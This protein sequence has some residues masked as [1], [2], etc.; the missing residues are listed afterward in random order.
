MTLLESLKAEI[1]GIE[2]LTDNEI[3]RNIK[4]AVSILSDKTNITYS[5]T[6][7][8]DI[9]TIDDIIEVAIALY[10]DYAVCMKSATVSSSTGVEQLKYND[11]FN[12]VDKKYSS[13]STGGGV[14]A[15]KLIEQAF[16]DF[17]T[18]NIAKR[19]TIAFAQGIRS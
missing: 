13:A 14:K 8:T 5:I 15:C 7:D 4:V 19:S 6:G 12:Q 16:D 10:I 3:N 18:K 9:S 17:I 11:G 2:I 1:T